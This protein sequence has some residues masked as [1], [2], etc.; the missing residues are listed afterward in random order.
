MK[1]AMFNSFSP[2]REYAFKIL[3]NFDKLGKNVDLFYTHYDNLTFNKKNVKKIYPTRLLVFRQLLNDLVFTPLKIPKDYDIYH[4]TNQG[5]SS[6]FKYLPKNKKVVVTIHD[7]VP[8]TNQVNKFSLRNLVTRNIVKQAKNADKI[9]AI[10]ENTKQDIIK[11]LN[12]PDSKINVVYNGIT[13]DVFYPRNKKKIRKELGIKDQKI[14]LHV[15][16]DEPRKN[17]DTILK[18][19]VSLKKKYPNIILFRV[20]KTRKETLDLV[21][22]LGLQDNFRPFGYLDEI[23]LAKLYNIADVFVFPSSYEGFGLPPLEAMASGCP[24]V[25]SN[26][27]SLK[28]VLGSS[29]LIIDPKDEI[30]LAFNINKIFKDNSLASSLIKKGIKQASKFT[31]E[32]C[33]KGTWKTY[34]GLF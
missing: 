24:V 33:A 28:E 1:V 27:T 34:E 4:M 15:T 7:L 16:I 32:N 2:L 11:Y 12:I 31:W 22:K 29:A 21:E 13:H 3:Y 6:Y 23:A 17:I 10:S 5:C 14:I 9:I 25:S 30:A 18:A 20:G 26:A 8:F 19:M